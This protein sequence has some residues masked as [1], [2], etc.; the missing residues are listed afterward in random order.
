M[1]NRSRLRTARSR[2]FFFGY[3]C[4]RNV[5]IKADDFRSPDYHISYTG[6]VD[7][8]SSNKIICTKN[9]TVSQRN[10]MDDIIYQALENEI[11]IDEEES[12]LVIA[13]AV[14]VGTEQTRQERIDR[15]QPRQ[16]YL[17]YSSKVSLYMP[18]VRRPSEVV[19]LGLHVNILQRK[20]P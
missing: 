11:A 15:R 13:A 1:I 12:A 8:K 16:L 3:Y 5:T 18:G 17:L 9:K 14:L 10:I 2:C 19:V 4:N 20:G 6:L 7:T